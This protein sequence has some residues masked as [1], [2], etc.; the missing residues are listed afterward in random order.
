MST[1]LSG[2]SIWM[3]LPLINVMSGS[4]QYDPLSHIFNQN[5]CAG[6]SDQFRQDSVLDSFIKHTLSQDYFNSWTP[7][8]DNLMVS[9]GNTMLLKDYYNHIPWYMAVQSASKKSM[10]KSYSMAIPRYF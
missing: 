10:S 7:N 6:L 1:G 3:Y 9:D 2:E 8:L 5:R 4:Q